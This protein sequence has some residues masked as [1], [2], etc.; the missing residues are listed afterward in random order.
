M[1]TTNYVETHHKVKV[2]SGALLTLEMYLKAR[3]LLRMKV[4]VCGGAG[5]LIF[6]E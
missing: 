4:G 1:R 5:N 3:A 6:I 2:N